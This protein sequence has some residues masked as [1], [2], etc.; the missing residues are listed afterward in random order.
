[1]Q[2]G[3]QEQAVPSRVPPIRQVI[4]CPR[5]HRRGLMEVPR[6]QEQAEYTCSVCGY[7][8]SAKSWSA[9]DAVRRLVKEVRDQARK[10][11]MSS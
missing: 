2:D 7:S 10:N 6:T 4:D 9:D 11:S 1:M 8:V 5:C 3:S